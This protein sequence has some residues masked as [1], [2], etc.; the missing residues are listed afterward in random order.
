MKF[1][2]Y[3]VG[4][5]VLGAIALAA[6]WTDSFHHVIGGLNLVV[7]GAG[8]VRLKKLRAGEEGDNSADGEQSPF[9]LIILGLLGGVLA[10]LLLWGSFAGAHRIECVASL[11]YDVDRAT[12]EE[13][14]RHVTAAGNPARA[15]E[16]IQSRLARNMSADWRAALSASLYTNLI[17][18]ANAASSFERATNALHLALAV[19]RR[20]YFDGRLAESLLKQQTARAETRGKL[21]RL[22]RDR[23]WPA[24]VHALEFAMSDKPR[25]DWELPFDHWLY[26]AY[27]HWALVGSDPR[28]HVEKLE[29]AKDVAGRFKLD[30]ALVQARFDQ[31]R[32]HEAAEELA[33]L[34]R[35]KALAQGSVEANRLRAEAEAAR[36]E[37]DRVKAEAARAQMDARRH[38]KRAAAEAELDGLLQAA[39]ALREGEPQQ[40]LERQR[41]IY[42]RALAFAE[43]RQ[44]DPSNVKVRLSQVAEALAWIRAGVEAEKG[45]SR[46]KDLPPGTRA[47]IARVT[48]DNF[49]PVFGLELYVED[50]QG[51]PVPGLST[52]DFQITCQ[53]QAPRNVASATIHGQAPRLNVVLAFDTSGSMRPAMK[54]AIAAGQGLL[55]GLADRSAVLAKVLNFSGDVRTV[56]DWTSEPARAAASLSGLRPD[57][58]TALFDA[59]AR[60][61][62]ELESRPGERHLVLFTDGRNTVRSTNSDLAR[63]TV[64]LREAHVTVTA[65][66]LHNAGLDS[67]TLQNLADATSGKY[68]L[69]ASSADLI[70]KFNAARQGLRR[71]FH[72]F[73]VAPES[74]PAATGGLPIR[75]RIGGANAV[76][77][78]HFIPMPGYVTAQTP[79]R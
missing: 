64:R 63:L 45:K 30:P 9:R 4:A 36:S 8:L 20:S 56:C 51:N 16:L 58:D 61:G 75:V 79:S 19:A 42:Q 5:I 11:F 67:S 71:T 1:I 3:L 66:G 29:A 31:L 57:G 27:L 35:E 70:D 78:E 40:T 15:V 38:A 55:R 69:A 2:P 49:P 62:G 18:V 50:P 74:I 68:F 47:G 73:V 52:K 48:T 77:L 25:A 59:I 14:I 12:L 6:G 13:E 24:L 22:K 33:R 26:E 23:N 65:I 60:A 10:A 54:E 41:D 28:H 37:S 21:E 17:S 44:L 43:S 72:R 7:L 39:E 46:P 76:A 34:A 53:G 32:A